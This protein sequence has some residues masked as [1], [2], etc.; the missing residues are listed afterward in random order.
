M[1]QQRWSL[2]VYGI[3]SI[4]LCM[5]WYNFAATVITGDGVIQ[6]QTFSF[7]I[8]PVNVSGGTGSLFTGAQLGSGGQGKVN[9]W[10]LSRL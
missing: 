7:P 2:Y 6:N 5:S 10:A 9:Q 1:M 3:C 8:G 4:L